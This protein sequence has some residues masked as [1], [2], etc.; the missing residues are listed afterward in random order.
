MSTT[1][2]RL[3]FNHSTTV[4]EKSRLTIVAQATINVMSISGTV[5]I[6]ETT[7]SVSVLGMSMFILH[8]LQLPQIIKRFSMDA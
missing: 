2:T 3:Y 8:G 1:Q 4:L 6:M 7:M 5:Q